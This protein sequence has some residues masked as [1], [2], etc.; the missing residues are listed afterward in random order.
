MVESVI[1]KKTCLFNQ[2]RGLRSWACGGSMVVGVL[3]CLS[4]FWVV[5][6]SAQEV[7]D[8]QND[9]AGVLAQLGDDEYLVRQAETRRLLVDDGLTPG[10]LD[11]LFLASESPEQRHRLLRVARHHVLR[12]MIAERFK[13]LSATGSMGLSPMVVRVPDE[14][15]DGGS[16]AGVMA[17]LTLPGFPAY[18]L[19]EPGDVIVEFDGQ[20]IPEKVTGAMFTSMIKTRKAGD[21]IGLMLVRNGETVR[22]RFTLGNG[23]A[24][25]E[26]YSSG[27][28]VLAGAYQQ[29]WRA[30][31]AR[32]EALVGERE[33]P[34]PEDAGGAG[35]AVVD[36]P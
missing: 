34:E 16:R 3:L 15:A 21:E 12:R 20:A 2:I 35:D 1:H 32:M 23:Q 17:A 5:G 31:R 9:D 30:E 33:L 18:A 28:V 4:L 25:G 19:L 26:V 11:R 29:A 13:G 6:A 10:D 36:S 22:L 7:V 24:L 14:E 8:E 27:G